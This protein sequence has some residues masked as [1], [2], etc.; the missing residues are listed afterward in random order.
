MIA[1]LAK[2][3]EN[4]SEKIH[5][6]DAHSFEIVLLIAGVAFSPFGAAIFPFFVYLFSLLYFRGDQSITDGSM[7]F[8]KS[9]G[10]ALIHTAWVLVSLVVTVILKKTLNRERPPIKNVSRLLNLRWNEHNGSIPSGDTL[11]C[12]LF[13]GF[14]WLNYTFTGSQMILQWMLIFVLI[15]LVAFSRVYFHCHW[16]GDTIIG[17]V[18]GLGLSIGSFITVKSIY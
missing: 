16:I 6:M 18:I 9:V 1:K 8:W 5:S 3:D 2:M 11:Q 17:A 12:A 13:A 7:L 14:M 10:F 15:P 4:W